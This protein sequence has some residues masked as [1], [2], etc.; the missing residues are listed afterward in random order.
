MNICALLMDSA[1][2]LAPFKKLSNQ[3]GF[4]AFGQVSNCFTTTSII[5]FLTGKMPSDLEK[6][7]IG[8][9]SEF[10]AGFPVKGKWSWEGKLLLSILEEH[11]WEIHVYTDNPFFNDVVSQRFNITYGDIHSR[12]FITEIQKPTK[13]NKFSLVL[14]NTYHDAIAHKV[15]KAEAQQNIQKCL[16][17]WDFERSD[18]I[19]W[20]F[21]DH[22]DYSKITYK[23]SPTGFMTWAL[24]RDNTPNP[25]KPT[26]N[27]ISI[28]DFFPSILQ[29]LNIEN[30]D[31]IISAET[32]GVTC[33][34]D[35]NRIYF[36][37]DSRS[38]INKQ[39]STA[40]S[41][42]TIDKWS[43]L[44]G[45]YDYSQATQFRHFKHDP[46]SYGDPHKTISLHQTLTER[47]SYEKY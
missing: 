20:L 41:A 40:F 1:P 43:E 35:L 34:L 15:S 4:A 12:D 45:E 24:L 8:Y 6:G 22:G 13:K 27:L 37:E 31:L 42:V 17:N 33:P 18:S 10:S 29:K 2:Y 38:S 14:Y 26:T 36:I 44:G 5:S 30:D 28:R 23:I 21:A 11:D 25:I 47:F 39:N 7:G 19:F 46:L 16:Q 32:R 3:K 9:E